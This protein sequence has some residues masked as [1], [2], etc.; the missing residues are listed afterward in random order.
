MNLEKL[1]KKQ[2]KNRKKY[3]M[4]KVVSE[5]GIK[6]IEIRKGEY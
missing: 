5:M 6:E 1:N 4:K 3:K 2:V